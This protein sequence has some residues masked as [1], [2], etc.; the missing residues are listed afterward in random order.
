MNKNENAKPITSQK[1][2]KCHQVDTVTLDRVD[3]DIKGLSLEEI[4]Q[5]IAKDV[6]VDVIGKQWGFNKRK[7]N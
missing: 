4:A 6:P 5:D 3:Y 1:T 7:I 2:S